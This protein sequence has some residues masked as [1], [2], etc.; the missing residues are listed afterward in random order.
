M[1][2]NEWLV[3][4]LT[5]AVGLGGLFVAASAMQGAAYGVGLAV[6]AAAVGYALFL[7]K[8]HFDRIEGQH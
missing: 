7:I 4:L 6:F 1:E 5:V 2:L 8:R 3:L